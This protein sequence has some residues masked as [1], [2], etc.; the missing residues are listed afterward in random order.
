VKHPAPHPA[1]PQLVTA[2][3]FESLTER[4]TELE[5]RVAVLEREH[6]ITKLHN[7]PQHSDTNYFEAQG[8]AVYTVTT[9]TGANQ[10]CVVERC[11]AYEHRSPEEVAQRIADLLNRNGI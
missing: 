9:K 8:D 2:P 3:Q 1:A 6:Q 11:R 10:G 4:I 7:A 5:V